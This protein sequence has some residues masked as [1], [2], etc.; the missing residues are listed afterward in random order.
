[1]AAIV[2][3]I[4]IA[5]ATLSS[6]D[7]RDAEGGLIPAFTRI[8][9]DT[10]F[11]TAVARPSDGLNWALP[12]SDR[13]NVITGAASTRFIIHEP[14]RQVR[15]GNEYL[16]NRPYARVLARLAVAQPMPA[17]EI[18]A[19]DPL[20]LYAGDSAATDPATA[21][22]SDPKS[23]A[24]EV[25]ELLGGILPLEDGQELNNGEVGEIIARIEANERASSPL[26]P[27]LVPE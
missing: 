5:A 21:A 14:V 4:A 9:D 7:S 12:K 18:P 27:S 8:A 25:V 19:F 13:L 6:L 26:R 11:S 1:M 3:G 20:K 10:T 2:G 17:T 16:H 24:V 15:K 23:V 22:A